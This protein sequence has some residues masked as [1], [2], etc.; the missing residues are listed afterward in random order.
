LVLVHF[1]A[2]PATLASSLG[3][4]TSAVLNYA[5]NYRFTF[6]SERR[7][8]EAFPRFVVVAT[9]GLLLNAVLMYAGTAGLGLHY[10]LVQV[11]ATVIVLFWNFVA[12][13]KWSFASPS[14]SERER[15]Q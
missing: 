4:A 3:F 13:M 11:I 12:N 9:G 10:L 14:R 5:L 8:I 2:C 6:A 15:A 1:F 7:H